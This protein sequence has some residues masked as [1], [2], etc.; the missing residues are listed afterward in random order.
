M[1]LAELVLTKL[2]I[3]ELNE[4]DVRDTALLSDGH[5]VSCHDDE[6]ING[7]RIAE[8]CGGDWGP[9]RTI[10]HNLERCREHLGDYSLPE[11]DSTAHFRPPRRPACPDRGAPEEPG[12]EA[13]RQG[14]RAQ[15]LVRAARRGRVENQP[16]SGDAWREASEGMRMIQA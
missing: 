11:D 15:A 12:L 13:A 1:P 6:T 8:L 16:F 9:W 3:V 5:A 2:Q 14:R 7:E 4:K 10:T